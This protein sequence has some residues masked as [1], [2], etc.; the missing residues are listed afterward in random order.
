M[1]TVAFLSS[2]ID[3]QALGKTSVKPTK[4]LADNA[5]WNEIVSLARLALMANQQA[6]Q[7]GHSSLFV[8]EVLHAV[9]L[10]AATGDTLAR[11]TVWALVVDIVATNYY[12]RGQDPS[13]NLRELFYECSDPKTLK[14]FGM[15]RA[16]RTTEL[17]ALQPKNDREALDNHDG[18]TRFL[19]KVMEH[20]AHPKGET[21]SYSFLLRDIDKIRLQVAE[22]LASSM[23][24]SG[25]FDCFPSFSGHSVAGLRRFGHTGHR[26]S[27]R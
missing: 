11:S 7:P 5:H 21:P 1:A 6:K 3:L 10:I 8:P 22:R 15:H 27:R 20:C 19:I 9:T 2:N 23:D 26:R 24:E 14:L 16:S 25:H 12:A 18:L 13:T 17:L 4:N